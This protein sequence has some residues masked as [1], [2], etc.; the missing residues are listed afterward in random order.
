MLVSMHV[1][2]DKYHNLL[3][4][5]LIINYVQEWEVATSFDKRYSDLDWVQKEKHWPPRMMLALKKFL[6]NN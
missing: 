5:P 3:C 4:L 6:A 2:A 1:C